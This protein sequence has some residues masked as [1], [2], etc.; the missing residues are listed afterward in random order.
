M[1]GKRQGEKIMKKILSAILMTAILL[2]V[3]ASALA[4]TGVGVVGTMTTS[5]AT[6]DKA[7]SASG[8]IYIT[9]VTL[10]DEGKIAGVIFDATQPKGSFDT[11]G[12]VVGEAVTEVVTKY[13]IKDGYGMKKASKIGKE[14][15]E[16]MD[17]L[18]AWCIGK[19]PAEVIGMNL[20]EG[21]HATDVDLVAG[22]T[23][24]INDQLAALAKA[25]ANAK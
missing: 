5:A 24:H 16:Q 12:A 15:Y 3:A 25:V 14:W 13:D 22:C 7:G 19:T 23:V 17:A 4:A 1:R 6:A 9:A 18:S 21:G 10:D 20:D 11:T 2:T 8:Y